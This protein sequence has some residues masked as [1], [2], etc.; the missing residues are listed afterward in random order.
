M[1]IFSF[2]FLIVRARKRASISK[3]GVYVTPLERAPL[4][5]GHGRVVAVFLYAERELKQMKI[6]NERLRLSALFFCGA[7]LLEANVDDVGARMSGKC[8]TE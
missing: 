5:P 1:F 4:F 3:A 7:H 6:R 8:V 2:S